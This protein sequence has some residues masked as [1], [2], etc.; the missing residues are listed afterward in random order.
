MLQGEF[1]D[2]VASHEVKGKD[3]V[4]EELLNGK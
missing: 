4:E 2:V 1:R 3:G